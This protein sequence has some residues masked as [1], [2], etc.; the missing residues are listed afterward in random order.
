LTEGQSAEQRAADV[1]GKR[2]LL[3][4]A[5]NPLVR[6]VGRLPAK[7]HTKLLVAFVGTAVLVV[8]VGLLGLRVLGQSNDRAER[9]GALQKRAFAYGKLHSDTS[10]VRLLLAENYTPDFSGSGGR[11][12]GIRSRSR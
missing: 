4:A 7:V 1:V 9:L 5:D 11:G 2:R 6:A 10:H 12:R 8:A 3:S